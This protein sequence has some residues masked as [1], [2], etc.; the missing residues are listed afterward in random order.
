MDPP[1]V[2]M[3]TERF[4]ALWG[5]F[6]EEA[7]KLAS[8]IECSGMGMYTAIY[9]IV[10]GGDVSYAVRLHWC[11]GKFFF[12][13]AVKLRQSI[14]GDDWI[15]HYVT[16][17]RQYEI[18]VETIDLLSLHL[19][20]AI[21]ENKECKNVKDL[22]YVIWERC[23]LRYRYERK[24]PSFSDSLPK[25]REHAEA[26][27]RSLS[28]IV[29]NS[30]NRYE[31]YKNNYEA[32]LLANIVSEFKK[33][34]ELSKEDLPAYL[35]RCSNTIENY[36]QSYGPLLLPMSL[37]V[38]E[39]SLEK[40]LF[41]NKEDD[42]RDRIEKL[43]QRREK[44]EIKALCD[45]A[46]RLRKK[47]FPM[48]LVYANDFC[49]SAWPSDT[50]CR[51]VAYAYKELSDLLSADTCDKTREVLQKTLSVKITKLGI[52]KDLSDYLEELIHKKDY[53]GMKMGKILLDSVGIK[54]EKEIFYTLYISKLAARLLSLRFNPLAE[55]TAVDLFDFP[56]IVKKK[57]RRIFDDIVRSRRE[58]EEFQQK[59]GCGEYM[60]KLDNENS[61]FFYTIVATSG[62]WPISE[63]NLQNIRMPVEIN[64]I[65]Q[66]F[67]SQYLEKHPRRK[68]AWADMASL[69][70]IEIETDRIYTVEMP[71]SYY[72]VLRLIEEEP[73]T[74]EQISMG[75][76]VCTKVGM[77]ILESLKRTSIIECN[78]DVYQL[79]SKFTHSQERIHV[80]ACESIAKR[81]GNRKSYYQAWISKTLKKAGAL[82]LSELSETIQRTHT[83]LFNWNVHEYTDALRN[84]NDRGLV[85]ITESMVR[86]IP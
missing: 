64:S 15:D 42:I 47:V 10:S 41:S 31:Y 23:I 84:L 62:V 27:L 14:E 48:F 43:L 22:G 45:G 20:E 53:A 6:Q 59:Y 11:I 39:E 82:G 74:M 7:N 61:I 32:N 81:I 77:N 37:P 26:C 76:G 13:L 85:E 5:T 78:N 60:Y 83:E 58:N 40:V 28:K 50:S 30:E 24:L 57:I 86:Y 34:I 8:G 80:L 49:L 4:G 71:L 70:E 72:S 1:V 66:T 54:E 44:G 2:G 3:S 73:G 9:Q 68:L 65:A 35:H 52:G 21:V 51:S 79:N 67:A 12:A 18:T 46:R 29:I 33:E 63:D 75:A 56:W 38:L 16:A 36:I 69:V 17:F 55:K 19:N 25:K